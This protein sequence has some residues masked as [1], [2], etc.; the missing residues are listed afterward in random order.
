MKQR[1][2]SITLRVRKHAATRQGLSALLSRPSDQQQQ[3]QQST[4]SSDVTDQHSGTFASSSMVDTQVDTDHELRVAH[5][6]L[7]SHLA[8]STADHR[9]IPTRSPSKLTT[10]SS[11]YYP[12]SLVKSLQINTDQQLE[13]SPGQNRRD[14]LALKQ[15]QSN[16]N[17]S[18]S[19]PAVDQDSRTTNVARSSTNGP[20]LIERNIA[21]APEMR[22]REDVSPS[23]RY[24]ED[25]YEN[26]S[27]VT[28]QQPTRSA[29]T[30]TKQRPLV[31]VTRA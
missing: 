2:P 25:R 13:R 4:R 10:T 7:Q 9:L 31:G 12:V 20:F 30:R 1:G 5:T 22:L 26:R 28:Q 14:D 29:S 27:S 17:L 15:Y 16:P 19:K 11:S 6:N 24:R 21:T 3:Q 8:A 18:Y 23:R